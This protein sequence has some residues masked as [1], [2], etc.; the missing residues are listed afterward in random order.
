M[1]LDL[2]LVVLKAIPDIQLLRATDPA[3]TSQT[4][5][6]SPYRPVSVMPPIRRDISV[7][8]DSDHLSEDLGDRVRDALSE[9]ATCVEPVHILQQTP[10]SAL[11]GPALDRLG[12]RRDQKNLLIRVVPRHVD[13]TLSNHEANVFTRPHLHRAAPRHHPAMG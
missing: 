11:P 3:I 10:C 4:T 13:K 8:V 2:L 7:V 9:D 6:L 1:G 12:A 5:D